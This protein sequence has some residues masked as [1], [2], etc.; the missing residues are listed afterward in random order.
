MASSQQWCAELRLVQGCQVQSLHTGRVHAQAGLLLWHPVAEFWDPVLPPPSS[1]QRKDMMLQA[2]A[3]AT[4]QV[5]HLDLLDGAAG[6]RPTGHAESVSC[7]LPTPLWRV[8]DLPYSGAQGVK[9]S[10]EWAALSRV[11]SPVENLTPEAGGR[12][13]LVTQLPH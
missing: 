6:T 4:C 11:W 7:L 9:V 1:N 13:A 3:P 2:C 8:G 12:V 5:T 10:L